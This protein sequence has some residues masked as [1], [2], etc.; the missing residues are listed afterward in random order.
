M[1]GSITREAARERALAMLDDA[2]IVLTD[3]ERAALEIVD[4]GFDDLAS[5]GLQLHTYVNTGRYCAK[6]LVLLPDQT[7]PEHRH[8]PLDG[9]PGKRETFRCRTGR[10]HLFVEGEPTPEPEVAPPEREEHYTAERE[11]VL[12]PGE[13]F[14]IPPDTRH[15]FRA[16]E[17][18]AVVSEFSSRSVDEADVF[19]DPAVDRLSG[20]EY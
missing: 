8:P 3:E 11:V 20:V 17:D 10:A 18:G 14:T 2:G 15:W 9:S 16:G 6:E 7:C 4:F 19:T 12:E 5:V 13:Q 1:P